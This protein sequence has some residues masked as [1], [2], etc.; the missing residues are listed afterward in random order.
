MIK[1]NVIE[2][3]PKKGLDIATPAYNVVA[4]GLA[5]TIRK[6][7]GN[8]SCEKDGHG[9]YNNVITITSHNNKIPDGKWT[10]F[11]CTDFRDTVELKF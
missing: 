5:D 7:V 3:R 4:K 2:A 8:R 1:V 11:C 10:S 6:S 9:L